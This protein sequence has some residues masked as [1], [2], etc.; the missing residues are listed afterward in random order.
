MT[1]GEVEGLSPGVV[2]YKRQ[3][4]VLVING[5]SGGGR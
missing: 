2:R 1:S 5:G 4:S 3:Q